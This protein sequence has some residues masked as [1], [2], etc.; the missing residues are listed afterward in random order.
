MY[1]DTDKG[2]G[3]T[4]GW[5]FASGVFLIVAALY[6]GGALRIL[7]HKLL[8]VRY[9]LFSGR[10]SQ[11]LVIVAIDPESLHRLPTWPWPRDYHATAVE[12]LLAAGAS[13]VAFDIDFSSESMP[14]SD[15]RFAAALNKAD[16]RVTLAAVKQ[17]GR[18]AG[19]DL[20]EPLPAFMN[21]AALAS[22]SV[23]PD[24]DGVVRRMALGEVWDDRVL[25]SL[26][27][28]LAKGYGDAPDPYYID[29][30]FDPAAI[31]HISYSDVISGTFDAQIVAGKTVLIGA[32]AVQLGD[33]LPVPRYGVLAGVDVLG[34]AYES[35]SGGRALSHQG[36]GA[37]LAAAFV[38][39]FAFGAAFRRLTWRKSLA[40]LA[41]TW[42]GSFAAVIWL[43]RAGIVADS[44]PLYLAAGLSF[45]AALISRS[46]WQAILLRI[47]KREIH[48]K[49][50]M[51]NG[52]VHNSF[53]AI[54]IMDDTGVIAEANKA[55]IEMFGGDE[56][57][58]NKRHITSLVPS[59]HHLL[60][61]TSMHFV[62][63]ADAARSE[64]TANRLDGSSF[65]VEI[66]VRQMVTESGCWQIAF[67]RDITERK[68]H[69]RELEHQAHHDSLTGLPNRAAL[70]R[71]LQETIRLS[72][73][74]RERFALIILDLDRF[75][76]VNDTLGHHTGDT[77]LRHIAGRLV[78]PLRRTDMIARLGGDEFAV[79][80]TP[81]GDHAEIKTI[82]DR[83]Q[84]TLDAPIELDGM[85]LDIGASIGVAYFP[86]DSTDATELV[87][88][89]DIAMYTAKNND[90][91]VAFYDRSKDRT[92]VRHLTLSGELKRAIE[93]NQLTL[94]FQPKVDVASREISGVET[95]LRW[96]H[97]EHGFVPPDEFVTLAE[98][99]GLIGKLT[100]WVLESAI[101]QCGR[102]HRAGLDL[103]VG[104]NLSVRNLQD[105]CL[106]RLVADLL[107]KHGVPAA[108]VVLE[109]TESAIMADPERARAVIDELNDLGLKLS[110][111]DFGT[112]YSSLGYLKRL[113]VHEIKID[114]SFV[115]DMLES[116]N[117]RVIVKSTVD[118]AHN[119]GLSVVAEGVENAETLDALQ[120]LGT[121][122]AQG[123]F[124]SKPLPPADFEAWLAEWRAPQ[125]RPN[126][127]LVAEGGR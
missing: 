46:D 36:P 96:Q 47:Q 112:G 31:P 6:L 4:R 17:R 67:V 12:N 114:R 100:E 88:K 80:L 26:P 49:E 75:K 33:Y 116:E 14:A 84:K 28:S 105:N 21:N 23:R 70:Y 9:S 115:I 40:L 25:P 62:P 52:V 24:E 91:P 27:A 42:A 48:H 5:L 98:R 119:L 20:T 95:L 81:A 64:M 118:L 37:T 58:L 107:R 69:Q 78:K 83:L 59:A 124:I 87:Q 120:A 8:D 126:L 73:H 61:R 104:I 34:L 44:A 55:A 29:F 103:D 15:A 19:A 82:A 39:A 122:V 30:G 10:A 89:A 57:G 102:W 110:I 3:M 60:P 53:D 54:F 72:A 71:T 56:N 32:T 76:E 45:V 79:I 2:G 74:T 121:D 94:Y 123:Y 86:E 77:L 50:R 113:P 97:P 11:D 43:Y 16:G 1:R 35:L 63:G 111:D 68:A 108:S 65:P 125:Q 117:D 51:I 7:D 109:I 38:I 92:S 90:M 22:V 41:L 18:G 101:A 127:R 13:R 106:P 66:A 93:E 85:T 99:T